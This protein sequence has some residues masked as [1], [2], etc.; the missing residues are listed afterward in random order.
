MD[1][2]V[3]EIRELIGRREEAYGAFT[4][5][6]MLSVGHQGAQHHTRALNGNASDMADRY[7]CIDALV[8]E[9]IM[10]LPPCVRSVYFECVRDKTRVLWRWNGPTGT[11]AKFI[12]FYW[13]NRV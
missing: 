3:I 2:R 5:C 7:G 11:H 10:Q 8:V 4:T 9:K 6:R 12:D 1:P 13:R